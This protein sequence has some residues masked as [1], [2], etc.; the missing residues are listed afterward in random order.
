MQEPEQPPLTDQRL[1]VLRRFA[2][3]EVSRKDMLRS[4][5]GALDINFDPKE[6][7]NKRC[8]VASLGK[9]PFPI[10]E[11]GIVIT[12]EHI[13]TRSSISASKVSERTG[14]WA[15]IC[16]STTH[17]CSIPAMRT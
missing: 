16:R 4:L 2:L 7:P 3:L 12:R 17:M 14:Y 13:S 6:D 5:A 8:R 10:S 15:T 1:D 11:P 9:Q